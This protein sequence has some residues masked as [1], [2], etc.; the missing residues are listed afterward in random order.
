MPG[1]RADPKLPCL[2]ASGRTTN[3]SPLPRILRN[4]I[5]LDSFG[6][7]A[8]LLRWKSE[9][10]SFSRKSSIGIYAIYFSGSSQKMALYR[11]LALLFAVFS[12]I[13]FL[14]Y[15]CQ[16]QIGSASVGTTHF[17]S[18]PLGNRTVDSNA[19]HLPPW[20]QPN[21]SFLDRRLTP[22]DT[23]HYG[24]NYDRMQLD[25]ARRTAIRY[26]STF[27]SNPS[28]VRE[29]ANENASFVDQWAEL[30]EKINATSIQVVDANAKLNSATLDYEDVGSKLRL[31]GPT[32][33]IGL[34][35]SQKNSQLEDWQV[36]GSAGHCV[37]EEIQRSRSK[38]LGNGV[39]P[40]DG[41]DVARQT[42]QIL[43]SAGFEPT[44]VEYA[45]LASQIQPLLRERSEWHQMLT[46][47]YDD[48]RQKLG[49]LDSISAAF[50]KLIRDYRHRINQHV[51]WIRNLDP[52]DLEDVQTFR[53]GLSSL[54]DSRRHVDFGISL[55]QKWSSDTTS[56]MALLFSIFVVLALRILAKIWLKGIIRRKRMREATA[57]ARKC[58][59]SILTPLVSLA[60]PGVL[61]LTARWF[62]SGFVTHSLLHTSSAFYAASLVALIVEVPRQ[63]LRTNGF[64]EKHLNIDLPRRQRAMAYLQVIGIGLVLFAYVVTLAKRIDHGTWSGSVARL[65]FIASLLLVAWTAHLALKPKGGFLE[66]LIEKFGGHVFYRIRLLFYFLGVGFPLAMIGLTALGYEFTATEI[67]K[68]AGLM[69]VS[70]L[71]GATLWSAVKFLCSS[72]WHALT[73]TRVQRQADDYRGRPSRVSGA[74][75]E[76]SLE[77]KHQIAFLGQCALAIAAFVCIGWLWIDILPNAQMGNPV[78]WTVQ[79]NAAPSF[80]DAQVQSANRTDVATTNITVL[81][82]VLAGATLFVAFQM[83]KLLPSIFD[84]LVLQQVNFDEAME[85]LSL[86]FGRCLLFGSGCFI[87]G[88]LVGLRWETIQWLAVGLFIGLGI[89][90][91][92]ILRNLFGGLVVMFEKPAR[93]G[94][95]ITVGN[96]TG[97]VSAQKLRTTVLSDEEGREVI[98]P[99]K[100]FVSQDVVNWMGAGRLTVI[101]IEVAVTRDERPADICRMLQQLLVEQPELLLNPAPQATL[102]CVSQKFQRIELR[103]WVE[104]FQDAT[105]YR[106]SL[107]TTVLRYLE[108]RNLLAPNQPSQPTLR[109]STIPDTVGGSRMRTKRS[110]LWF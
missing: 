95:L 50:D 36:D 76:Q 33:T 32:P 44:E 109:E 103:A 108:K 29:I 93:L 58:V 100:N 106:E 84:V 60:I 26:R 9:C 74:L 80:L 51:T 85:H 48:Y 31:H 55:R 107:T 4:T 56:G 94:D 96:V 92:D 82:L 11:N 99:N 47:G 68:R 23:P 49:E 43:A 38:Q 45:Q 14:G 69:F 25:D 73:G 24:L 39:I 22:R 67:V 72:A 89:A 1:C 19:G 40:Y 16:A 57:D 2:G 77:L 98:V 97:R 27:S 46:Q 64:L 41:R 78:V 18:N 62:G 54:F 83:A 79:G 65:G 110:A 28:I 71:L 52:I 53:V 35:L 30:A 102:I 7:I 63:L 90:L 70:I 17:D 8:Y 15:R 13:G 5:G 10:F 87:A 101:P 61:F 20:N 105:R 91:Q 86:V 75:A 37:N 81:H 104:E 6:V 12:H 21:Q 3:P 88:R 59:A 42:A 66:P 34:L